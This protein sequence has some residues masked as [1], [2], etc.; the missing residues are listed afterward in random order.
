MKLKTSRLFLKML[1]GLLIAAGVAVGALAIVSRPAPNHPLFKPGE[2]LVMAHRGGRRLGPESTLYTFRQ[3]VA[4]GVDVLEMDLRLTRDNRLVVFHDETLERTTNGTGRIADLRLA[5][6]KVLDAGA[7]WSPDNG[8]NHPLRGRSLRVPTLEEVFKTFPHTRMNLE[9]KDAR[10]PAVESLCDL[11]QR[12]GMAEHIMVACFDAGVLK[13]FRELCPAVATSA[14]FHEAAM[15]F[16]LQS[17]GLQSLYSPSA[18][19]LQVP[20]KYGELTVV[21]RRFIEAAHARHMS[22]HVWTVNEADDMRRLIDMGVDGIMTDDPLR[23]MELLAG[24]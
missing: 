9:I 8:K 6:V 5:D 1:A 23:L 22:V 19:A 13:Q 12:H 20:E 15:F 14:G 7:R 2:F 3:A 21:D 24:D 18:L 16:S 10:R 11:V 4:L 17:L